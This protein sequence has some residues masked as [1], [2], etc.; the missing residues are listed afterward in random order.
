MNKLVYI[1]AN[2]RLV[3]KDNEVGYDAGKPLKTTG[4]NFTRLNRVQSETRRRVFLFN[5][6]CLRL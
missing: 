6:N 4:Y 5:Y 2:T 1:H 3:D